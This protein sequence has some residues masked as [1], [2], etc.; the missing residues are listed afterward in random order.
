MV[1]KFLPVHENGTTLN[2][3]MN[4]M[5]SK[6]R[7]NICV[8]GLIGIRTVVVGV[9]WKRGNPSLTV[10]LNGHG[11]THQCLYIVPSNSLNIGKEEPCWIS[12][13]HYLSLIFIFITV[14][15]LVMIETDKTMF[16]VMRE[17]GGAFKDVND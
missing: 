15:L 6:N 2:L 3:V 10:F 17:K 16:S 14:E 12:C 5:R 1:D 7:N 13:L 8:N 4:K 11:L 9:D